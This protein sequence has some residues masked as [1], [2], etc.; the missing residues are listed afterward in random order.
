MKTIAYYVYYKNW[1]GWFH[2]GTYY[3]RD[4]KD[5][6]K[7]AIAGMSSYDTTIIGIDVRRRP[8][9]PRRHITKVKIPKFTRWSPSPFKY[10]D[11]VKS[12]MESQM[13]TE[14][15][16]EWYRADEIDAWL[17]RHAFYV[18]TRR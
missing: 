11:K 9:Q 2:S 14:Q 12:Q 18:L 17:K 15:F 4:E 16:G 10:L 7:D 3:R 8:L 13:T 6:F 5:A 1:K